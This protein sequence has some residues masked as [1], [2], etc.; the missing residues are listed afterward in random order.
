MAVEFLQEFLPGHALP[1]SI[2]PLLWISSQR[3]PSVTDTLLTHLMTGATGSI[4]QG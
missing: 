2:L 3:F 1:Q 4:T